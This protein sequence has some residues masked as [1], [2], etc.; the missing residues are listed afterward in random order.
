MNNNSKILIQH[1]EQL[2]RQWATAV[3]QQHNNQAEVD[4]LEVTAMQSGT[5]TRI[6]LQVEHNCSDIARQWFVKLPS[7]TWRARMITALPRLLKT[8]ARFYNQLA[9]QLPITIP[10]CLA[11]QSS[12]GRGTTIV[13]ADLKEQHCTPG[14]AGDSLS[15]EQACLVTTELARLHARFWQDA[16]LKNNNPWLADSVRQLEDLLGTALAVPLMRR[17]L[18]KAG[19]I[20]NKNLHSPAL[21]YAARRRKAMQFLGNAPQTLTHHDC[22]PG[23]LFWQPDGRPGLLDWQLVR[24]G[25]GIGDLAYLLCT[26]LL[27]EDRKNHEAQLVHHYSQALTQHGIMSYCDDLMKRYRAHCCYTFEAMVVTLAIGNMMNSEENLALISRAASA[28]Q[29]LDSFSAWQD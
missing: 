13:L 10:N 24:L 27:P 18:D 11:A 21:Q 15:I 6:R 26:T 14:S 12:F 29:D 9:H 16:A 3:L 2:T 28:V 20:I 23:N 22:H 1:P 5:T 19:S 8:E 25:E 4:K 7:R 17:G